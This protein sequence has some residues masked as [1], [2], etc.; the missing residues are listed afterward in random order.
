MK[1]PALRFV[2]A[3]LLTCFFLAGV[4]K[5]TAQ[6]DWSRAQKEVWKGVE[7]FYDAFTR[8]DVK[9]IS[10][11]VHPDFEGWSHH[12]VLPRNK[13]DMERELQS[14]LQ[15]NKVVSYKIKPLTIKV[16]GDVAFVHYYYILNS[17]SKDG[18]KSIQQGK[19]TD[20]LKKQGGSWLLIGDHGGAE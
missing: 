3:A 13:A 15:V 20:I 17:E 7:T 5:L 4:T 10:D 9:V 1:K 2:F 11:L 6:E 18:K 16:L 12:S 19:Y 8:G 14:F